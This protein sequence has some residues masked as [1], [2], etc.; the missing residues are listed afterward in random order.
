MKEK[1][2]II[3]QYLDGLLSESEVK[4]F[5]KQLSQNAGLT[6]D[7]SEARNIHNKL[8]QLEP[9]TAPEGMVEN[10]LQSVGKADGISI[11]ETTTFDILGKLLFYL[12]VILFILGLVYTQLFPVDTN[13]TYG[14]TDPLTVYSLRST[15]KLIDLTNY[16][17][18]YSVGPRTYFYLGT[19]LTMMMVYWIDKLWLYTKTSSRK[20]E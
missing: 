15:V 17:S 1:E 4:T 7:L 18:S 20:V 8:Q 16:L 11:A 12:G 6:K 3:W 14:W 2:Q 13:Q 10:I 19:T 9:L 5:E